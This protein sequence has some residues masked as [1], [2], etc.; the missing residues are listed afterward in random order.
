MEESDSADDSDSDSDSDSEAE[1]LLELEKI[2]KERE[3]E[4]LLKQRAL[5]EEQKMEQ[6]DIAANS[7][8]L[9]ASNQT[10]TKK[11]Y[12]D[13]VFRNQAKKETKQEKSFVNDTIRSDFHRKFLD[14]F[15]K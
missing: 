15:V 8:P 9:L 13:T 11:W 6:R 12:E 5:E 14:R 2:R 4:A 3:A 1:L 7:N 10:V